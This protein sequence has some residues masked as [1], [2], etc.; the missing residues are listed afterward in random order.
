MNYK[1]LSIL[2]FTVALLSCRKEPELPNIIFLMADDHAGHALGVDGDNEI[3]TPHLAQLANDGLRFT[4][5]Y[6]TSPICMASR[7]TVFTGMYE[8][9]TGYNFLTGNL[10]KEYWETYSYAHLLREQ[11]YYTGFCGKWGFNIPEGDLGNTNKPVNWSGFFDMWGGFEGI[12]QGSYRTEK[13][14]GLGK[15]SGE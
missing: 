8:Y 6:A 12:G 2:L 3:K 5:C 14:P 4:N 11:G 10:S 15:Y 7:A 9:K 13:N 1:I